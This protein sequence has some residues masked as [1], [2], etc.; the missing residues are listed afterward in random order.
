MPR[1]TPIRIARRTDAAHFAAA[2]GICPTLTVSE[3]LVVTECELTSEQRHR[4]ARR[5]RRV[6]PYFERT[7]HFDRLGRRKGLSE[8]SPLDRA[9][10]G[11]L[12]RVEAQ[13]PA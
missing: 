5:D 10:F 8:A 11:L 4:C 3:A 13:V 2:G 6:D 12:T 1:L 9:G 7:L